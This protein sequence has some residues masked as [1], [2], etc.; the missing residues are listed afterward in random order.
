MNG[1]KY[2]RVQIRY[3]ALQLMEIKCSDKYCQSFCCSPTFE[4]TVLD[5]ED[6]FKLIP[7]PIEDTEQEEEHIEM[8]VVNNLGGVDNQPKPE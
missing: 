1:R 2:C 6:P 5:P 4:K 8:S 3:I 7:W